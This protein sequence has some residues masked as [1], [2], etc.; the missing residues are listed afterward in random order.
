MAFKL[1]DITLQK[2]CRLVEQIVTADS[3]GDSVNRGLLHAVCQMTIF[4][5]PYTLTHPSLLL[6]SC[7]KRADFARGLLKAATTSQN[8]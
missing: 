1:N 6:V 2:V 4:Y 5:V 8:S 3:S 7:G